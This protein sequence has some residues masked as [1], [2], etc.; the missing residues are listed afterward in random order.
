MTPMLGVQIKQKT[1][2]LFFARTSALL[3]M[4]LFRNSIMPFYLLFYPTLSYR[5][6]V[7]PSKSLNENLNGLKSVSV[8]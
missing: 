3:P 6:K 4:S 2:A 7:Q 8:S 1:R 5:L